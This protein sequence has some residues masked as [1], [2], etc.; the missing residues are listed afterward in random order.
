MCSTWNN[1]QRPLVNKFH[2]TELGCGD[3][4]NLTI[5]AFY[6]P[7]ATFVGVDNSD[8]EL[9]LAYNGVK[10]LQ[11]Q[12][13][14]F[15]CKDVC[16]LEPASMKESDYIIA[17]GL[18]SWV[19]DDVR[20]AIL[21]FCAHNLQDEGLAY[22]SYNAQPGWS[23]RN[24]IRETLLRSQLVQTAPLEEK[25]QMAIDVVRQLL[26]DLPARDYVSAVLLADELE[27]VI[28]AKPWYV[29]HE[30]L[31]EVNDGFWLTD[32]VK[33]AR[34]HGL[35][36]VTDAQFCR[37]E[38][39]VPATLKESLSNRNF[40][41]VEQE[42]TADLLCN[43]YFRASILCRAD[44]PQNKTSRRKLME[45]VYIAT[46]L[47]AQSD[48]LDLTDGVTERFS[49]LAGHE[50]TLDRAI[51]KAAIL[52]LSTQ[53]PRGIQLAD[54]YQQATKL[55]TS[56]SCKVPVDARSLLTDEVATLFEAGQINLRVEEPVYDTHIPEYPKIH[57]LARFEI[58]HREALSTPFHLPLP[59]DPK[60]MAVVRAMD[61][62]R[63]RTELRGEFG[64]D[65]VE[66]T[67]N[68]VARWGLLN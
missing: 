49:S 26:E 58:E 5:L 16:D 12:N 3:G 61:G 55:L 18:Y 10:F 67:L 32:F 17:H 59:L 22:I 43:R 45:E 46:S 25:G 63:S 33:K 60:A 57:A 24:L 6:H 19:P 38:G 9:E 29:F 50:I 40:D 39:Q 51:T 41:P 23:T 36:Y 52:V 65:L 35:E 34:F 48:P 62:S 27:R 20:H 66:Q 68:T 21:S 53:W 56:H 37:P 30:Y 13:I 2:V 14:Q 15:I 7:Y 8:A 1:G 4:T 44:A 54:L 11:L 28:N 64:D 42:E 31:T 47:Q